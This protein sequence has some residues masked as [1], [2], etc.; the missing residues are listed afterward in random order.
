MNGVSK[1]W[2]TSSIGLACALIIITILTIPTI[3]RERVQARRIEAEL[4]QA[5]FESAAITESHRRLEATVVNLTEELATAD[6]RVGELAS[7]VD[8]LT[9][10]NLRALEIVDEVTRLS[11]GLADGIID[12][13]QLGRELATEINRALEYVRELQEADGS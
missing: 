6:T 7:R 4:N 12:V 1:I 2:R 10:N 9:T 11:I 3:N 8:T 13:E 5:L